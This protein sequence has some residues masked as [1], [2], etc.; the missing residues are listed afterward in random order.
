MVSTVNDTWYIESSIRSMIFLNNQKIIGK[1]K[2]S[3]KRSIKALNWCL[4][5]NT[6]RIIFSERKILFFKTINRMVGGQWAPT[7]HL[8]AEDT[9]ICWFIWK[10]LYFVSKSWPLCFTARYTS[11][12]LPSII[13][14]YAVRLDFTIFIFIMQKDRSY[15]IWSTYLCYVQPIP[16]NSHNTIKVACR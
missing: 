3:I 10:A 13:T 15:C 9:V 2:L 6:K 5:T 7:I 12:K 16:S 8:P 14:Q 4:I 1:F 11:N